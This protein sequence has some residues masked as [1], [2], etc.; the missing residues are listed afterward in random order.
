MQPAVAALGDETVNVPAK[1]FALAVP[2]TVPLQSVADDDE[3]QV[4]VTVPDVWLSWS[5]TATVGKLEDWR[6]PVQFPASCAKAFPELLGE[7]ELP[8]HAGTTSATTRISS[9]RMSGLSVTDSVTEQ[10]VG[11]PRL[12]RVRA[13]V[14]GVY[15]G[16]A[17]T[18]H[19]ALVLAHVAEAG[20]VRIAVHG[21]LAPGGYG[22]QGVHNETASLLK[23]PIR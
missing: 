18:L 1:L 11:R 5:V 10:K 15:I 7:L 16:R 17:D 9:R 23:L 6:L 3:V 8:L 2:E 20:Q 13:G 21:W 4:P 12:S 19:Q 22:A 14:P